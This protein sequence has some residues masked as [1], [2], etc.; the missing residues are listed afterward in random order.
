M[1]G[2]S[3][4]S[5]ACNLS[6]TVRRAFGSE[7]PDVVLVANGYSVGMAG[8]RW[9]INSIT[10]VAV[11]FEGGLLLLAVV[12]AWLLGV[13]LFEQVRFGWHGV[14]LSVAGTCPLLLLL[15]WG[16]HSR[17]KPFTQLFREIEGQVLP[18]F[19]H[20]SV[21]ELAVISVLAGLAEES[22]FRG[23]LQVALA[24]WINPPLALLVASGLFGLA[25][26]ITPT[27]ALLALVIGLYL[28]WMLMISDNLLVPILVH[29]MYDFVAL[30]YLVRR[31]E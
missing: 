28:G 18:L 15:V 29:A 30:V 22:L 21:L 26:F 16:T 25:H 7:A 20:C 14:W 17:W 11:G 4:L 2:C 5:P 13:S 6:G 12:V 3:A 1:L 31:Y 24:D 19:A 10:L 8:E 23:V 27:Y 9:R